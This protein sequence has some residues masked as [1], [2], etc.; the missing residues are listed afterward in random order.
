MLVDKDGNPLHSGKRKEDVIEDILNFM[1]KRQ[2]NNEAISLDSD[3]DDDTINK[4]LDSSSQRNVVI[5][6]KSF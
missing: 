2:K 5:Y 6:Y 1:F 4:D 3:D